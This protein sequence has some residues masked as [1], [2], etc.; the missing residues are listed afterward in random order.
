M[1]RDEIGHNTV[2]Y[3]VKTLMNVIFPLITFK[4]ASNVILASG[5]GASNFSSAVISYVGLISS[6]GISSYAISEGSKIRRDREQLSN[7]VSEVFTINI[8]SM[9]LSYCVLFLLLIFV[10]RLASYSYL[11]LIYSTTILFNALGIEWYFTI[12]EKFDYITKRSILFQI[13][14]LALLFVLVRNENDVYWYVALT[15]MSSAGSGILNFIYSKRTIKIRIAALSNCKKHL[16]PI[17]IIWAANVASLIYVNADTIIIG[18]MNGDAA[19]GYYSAAVK[20]VKAICMPIGAISVV[21][22][23]Q[24]AES[25]SDN[26][27]EKINQISKRVMEF[28]SFFM[29]PC[30]VGLLCL[31]KESIL[32]ISGDEFLPGLTAERILL[33]DIFL[34]P[35]NSFIANQ[36][37]IPIKKEKTSMVAMIIA[38]SANI[39][40]DFFLIGVIGIDGAALATVIS[41]ALV[42]VI[43]LKCVLKTIDIKIIMR[44]VWKYAFSSLLILPVYILCKRLTDSSLVL[45]II[46]VLLSVI[47]YCIMVCILTK[48]NPIKKIQSFRNK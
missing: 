20:V 13:I 17:L 31:G 24:L 1:Y 39:I 19:V 36:V 48:Q 21:A 12:D 3:M 45:T 41:E 25:I 43:C 23:P 28:M 33:F 5:I 30:F 14:S 22:G 9:T 4:Y 42:F 34:S 40:L 15:A 32:L 18:L 10:G 8:V 29:F 35:L 38:A 26:N 2:I 16:R 11:I 46:T 37:M 47:S 44:N 7:F 6:L 27:Q